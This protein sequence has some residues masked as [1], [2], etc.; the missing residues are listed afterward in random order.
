MHILVL[1]FR[2]VATRGS[3]MQLG[4]KISLQFSMM[5]LKYLRISTKHG[6]VC[7]MPAL[8][9]LLWSDLIRCNGS[10][11][12]KL[13]RRVVPLQWMDSWKPYH[14]GKGL[15]SHGANSRNWFGPVIVGIILLFPWDFFGGGRIASTK[16]ELRGYKGEQG[17]SRTNG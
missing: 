8:I 7:T 4:L 15:A 13:V 16:E 10:L 17:P 2:S 9:I 12:R 11:H 3:L 14:S 1:R 5:Q 6:C